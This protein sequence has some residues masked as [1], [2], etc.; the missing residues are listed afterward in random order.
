MTCAR[1]SIPSPCW[2]SFSVGLTH[3]HLGRCQCF[4]LWVNV[5]GCGSVPRVSNVVARKGGIGRQRAS[6][7]TLLCYQHLIVCDHGQVEEERPVVE[8]EG[9]S[10]D[11]K[12][13]EKRKQQLLKVGILLS[14]SIASRS[15]VFP[16]WETTEGWCNLPPRRP[17]APQPAGIS[18]TRAPFWQAIQKLKR[19]ERISFA[20]IITDPHSFG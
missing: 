6:T 10:T 17:F 13:S 18:L 7:A 19:G 15:S 5:L 4:G 14:C 2:S 8:A 1:A 20:E 16:R 12:S 11:N 3:A 9:D